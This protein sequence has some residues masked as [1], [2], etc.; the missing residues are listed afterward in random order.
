MRVLVLLLVVGVLGW[1]G[2]L[3]LSLA[4]PAPDP[5]AVGA[6][7]VEA[8]RVPQRPEDLPAFEERMHG[9]MESA[10]EQRRRSVEEAGL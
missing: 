9:F 4:P 8:P 6:E 2:Y 1:I 7:T 10:G 3:Q 5:A